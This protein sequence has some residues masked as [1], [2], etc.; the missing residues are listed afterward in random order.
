MN[1]ALQHI[2][3]CMKAKAVERFKFRKDHP[4][5]LTINGKEVTADNSV[6]PVGWPMIFFCSAC[7]WPTAILDEEYF[8]TRPSRLCAECKAMDDLGWLQQAQQQ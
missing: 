1:P 6:L 3:E 5:A 2:P 7:G 4:L 8:L